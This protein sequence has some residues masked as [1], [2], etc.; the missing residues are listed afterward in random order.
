MAK[1]ELNAN[2]VFVDQSE[3]LHSTRNFEARGVCDWQ[4]C[5][6]FVE[7]LEEM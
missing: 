3:E 4:T 7:L 6:R 2:V 1:A 5:C